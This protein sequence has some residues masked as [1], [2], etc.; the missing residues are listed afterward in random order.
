MSK[1]YTGIGSRKLPN[2]I[3]GLMFDIGEAMAKRGYTLRSGAAD[4]ADNAFEEGCINADGVGSIF[5]PW[6]GF[7]DREYLVPNGKV[8][9]WFD[10]GE[11]REEAARLLSDTGVCRYIKSKTLP[12]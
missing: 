1:I 12:H 5:L 8:C 7:K 9:Y 11:R 10:H 6:E 3:E 2:D 4:G